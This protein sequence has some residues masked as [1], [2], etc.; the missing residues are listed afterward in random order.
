MAGNHIKLYS[1]YAKFNFK[2]LLFSEEPILII[3]GVLKFGGDFAMHQN[4]CSKG[5]K[6]TTLL[7]GLNFFFL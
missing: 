1:G 7:C 6:I 5:E 2:I 4:L 3:I